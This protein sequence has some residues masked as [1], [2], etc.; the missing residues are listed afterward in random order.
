MK[1]TRWRK[2]AKVNDV[3]IELSGAGNFRNLR[4]QGTEILRD[5]LKDEENRE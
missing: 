1:R 2:R 5:G 4:A 3:R